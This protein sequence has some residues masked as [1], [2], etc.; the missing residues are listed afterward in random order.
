MSKLNYLSSMLLLL[1]L[2]MMVYPCLSLAEK[3]ED[4]ARLTLQKTVISKK[5]LDT[6][7]VQKG[8]WIFDIIRQ[9]FGASEKKIIEILEEVKELNPGIKDIHKI[10]PGQELILPKTTIPPGAR[11]VP[12]SRATKAAT[13][14]GRAEGKDT[15]PYAVKEGETL[16]DIIHGELSATDEDIYRMMR[17]VKRLNPN[18]KNINKIYPGQKLLLPYVSGGD[19]KAR[20]TPSQAGGK[21]FIAESAKVVKKLIL[22][23]RETVDEKKPED[24]QE[25]KKK[26][27]LPPEK[28]IAV[29]RYILSRLNGA[30]MSEGKYF[31]PLF[32]AGQI[33]IDCSS[34]PV[35]EL[36]DGM[37]VLLDFSGS[38]PAGLREVIETTWKNYVIME[39]GRDTDIPSMV[40]S[41]VTTS[42]D[43][44]F[45]TVKDFR[46]IGT[47]P[48]VRVFVDWV[49]SEKKSNDGRAYSF[50]IRNVPSMSSALPG[51]IRE[52]ADKQGFEIVE[53]L[54]GS[55][56]VGL[57]ET[58][59]DVPVS[60]LASDTNM[61]LAES[62]VRALGL[63]PKT[64]A[65]VIIYTMSE[66]GFSLSL[67]VDLLVTAGTTGV[68][69]NGKQIPEQFI[70]GLKARGFEYVYLHEGD[71]KES[72]IASVL[73]A[74]NVPFVVDRFT[75]PFSPMVGHNGGD[76][77]LQGIRA[78]MGGE[79]LYFVGQ[80]IDPGISGLLMKKWRVEL[81][82]Y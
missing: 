51:N 28:K 33:T 80:D 30:V 74:L 52:Y 4:T 66:H 41:V 37:T 46:E 48:N 70:K 53:L 75:F 40:E 47:K 76:I 29:L 64:H 18:V 81:R 58:Y 63:D 68:I 82:R 15:R 12:D 34:V 14:D 49:V 43:Y 69:F 8:E 24:P 9:K 39:I 45:E 71:K 25:E 79:F 65:D 38:I 36:D 61:F 72:I 59:E 42:R 67:K 11:G 10:A 77:S 60:R 54:H 23:K 17:V 73:S 2:L 57:S 32:P 16:S 26:T 27:I 31:I 7:V 78:D 22:Q 21:S 1:F 56:V 62:L 6:Y 50:G 19:E 13:T 3:T 55:E 44:R 5:K 35:V 20:G